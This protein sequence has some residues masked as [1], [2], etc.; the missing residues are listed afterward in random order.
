LPYSEKGIETSKYVIYIYKPK[1]GCVN[2]FSV[3]LDGTFGLANGKLGMLSNSTTDAVDGD[4]LRVG[5]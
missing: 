4:E 1:V 3:E 2:N 5:V